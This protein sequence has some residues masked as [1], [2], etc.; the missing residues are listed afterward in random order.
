M[1][2]FYDSG[3]RFSCKQCSHCCKDEP[4]YVFL[5]EKEIQEI[6]GFLSLDA[7][8]FIDSYC[9]LIQMGTFYMVSIIER[10][11]HDCIFLT[12]SGCSIYQVRPFQCRSYPFWPSVLSSQE[13]WDREALECPG[14]NCGELH[15]KEEI[16]EWLKKRAENQP[17]IMYT[18]KHR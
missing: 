8:A 4:G 14:M 11:N 13:D 1:S 9:R 17:R 12:S 2:T 6:S 16:D 18:I 3:L 5:T 7:D 15:E 10:K